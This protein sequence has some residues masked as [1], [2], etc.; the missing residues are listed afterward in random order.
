MRTHSIFRTRQ[1]YGNN[2]VSLQYGKSQSIYLVYAAQ[3]VEFRKTL[4]TVRET[5]LQEQIWPDQCDY[6]IYKIRPFQ[7]TANSI[8]AL[9]NSKKK[10]YS[11]KSE[12]N[13]Y[14]LLVSA[15]YLSDQI[16]MLAEFIREYKEITESRSAKRLKHRSIVSS[17]Q[18]LDSSLRDLMKELDKTMRNS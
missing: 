1:D 2:H 8:A 5:F 11:K 12:S 16:E 4:E 15:H 3:F 10:H 7:I 14:S 18:N 17:L 6:I 13:R 9:A